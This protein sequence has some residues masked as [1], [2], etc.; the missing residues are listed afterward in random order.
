MGAVGH[1]LHEPAGNQ[2]HKGQNHRHDH[3]QRQHAAHIHG[4][5]HAADAL[6]NAGQSP[7]NFHIAGVAPVHTPLKGH[8]ARHLPAQSAVLVARGVHH[9]PL[10]EEQ[11]EHLIFKGAALVAHVH[12]L[13]EQDPSA[14]PDDEQIA[15]LSPGEGHHSQIAAG[16]GQ[17]AAQLSGGNPL[18][19]RGGPAGNQRQGSQ[20]QQPVQQ[21]R[22]EEAQ[23]VGNL[24]VSVPDV[25]AHRGEHFFRHLHGHGHALPVVHDRGGGA[26]DLAAGDGQNLQV[27]LNALLAVDAGKGRIQ[28]DAVAGHGDGEIQVLHRVGKAGKQRHRQHQLPDGILLLLI[29]QGLIDGGDL[30]RL[31][32]G[33]ADAHGGL[34]HIALADPAQIHLLGG[35]SLPDGGIGAVQ[36]DALGIQGHR[37]G[38][39]VHG[40][41][42]PKVHRNRHQA[43][44]VGGDGALDIHLG[45]R[46]FRRRRK[47]EN[48]CQQDH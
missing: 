37:I 45:G 4:Y 21:R 17:T 31:G 16:K 30:H 39:A 22:A 42:Q 23:N 38:Q 25:G 5:A 18:R 6:G 19:S 8:H 3:R 35:A 48:P 29:H 41:L 1:V 46:G 34:A 11:I 36:G 28:S 43:V 10:A 13:L 2:A 7:E 15:Q 47:A 33:I 9:V 12:P 40:R 20:R 44:A 32:Q 24:R 27:G 26:D 14:L